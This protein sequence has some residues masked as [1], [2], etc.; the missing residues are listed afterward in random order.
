M[1]LRTTLTAG[2]AL[3]GS[4][5]FAQDPAPVAPSASCREG[6]V[7]PVARWAR[8]SNTPSYTGYYVG[9][10]TAFPGHERTLSEGTWGWDYEGWCF[11]R[12]VWLRWSHGRRCQGGTGSYKTDR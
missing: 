3:I 4:G 1:N 6:Y 9:G 5:V 10:D 2:L 7:L 12:R 11:S 8:P